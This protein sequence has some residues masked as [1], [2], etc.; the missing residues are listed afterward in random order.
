MT[1]AKARSSLRSPGAAMRARVPNEARA[2]APK[3]TPATTVPAAASA[4]ACASTPANVSA[5][6]VESEIALISKTRSVGQVR[7]AKA[8][9]APAPHSSVTTRPPMKWLCR[10]KRPA[11]TEGPSERYNPPSAQLATTI[12][13]I[14][15]TSGRRRAGMPTIGIS[16]VTAPGRRDLADTNS[17]HWYQRGH[18][19]RA[20]C[21]RLRHTS[22][23]YARETHADQQ[24]REDEMCRGG[25]E[26]DER[27]AANRA[28]SQAGDRRNAVDQAGAAG[29]VGRVQVDQRRSKRRKRRPGGDA[30]HDASD[31]EDPDI[32]RDDEQDEGRG[33]E[34][35]RSCK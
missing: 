14:P 3:P 23:D 15:N 10:P 19:A 18:R 29:R 28:Q 21:R 25:R 32:P 31:Q 30:L 2:D 26:L 7:N 24:Q 5:V 17:W 33:F 9:R 34:C 12:G 11:A 8:V 22:N 16:E 13:T 20:A 4:R 6:P 35:D 1:S 27:A